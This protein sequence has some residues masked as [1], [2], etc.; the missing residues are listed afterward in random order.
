MV[1]SSSWRGL[2]RNHSWQVRN[3][4]QDDCRSFLFFTFHSILHSTSILMWNQWNV[5]SFL[6]CFS[7]YVDGE[8]IHECFTGLWCV[9]GGQNT[10]SLTVS[11]EFTGRNGRKQTFAFKM[12]LCWLRI[13][14]T[15]TA[16]GPKW[17]LGSC[18]ACSAPLRAAEHGV[19]VN[20]LANIFHC[21]QFQI[22]LQIPGN[23][24]RW[25][26]EKHQW[27][28]EEAHHWRAI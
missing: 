9:S 20:V 11:W 4:W 25:D 17:E 13:I 12:L 5:A 22:Y 18:S 7:F 23:T 6:C 21:F 14:I 16:I 1:D 2:P 19:K 27:D 26:A 8:I 3:T 24:C 10:Y 15:T 28:K